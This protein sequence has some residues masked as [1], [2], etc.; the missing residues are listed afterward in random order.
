MRIISGIYKSRKIIPPKGGDIVRPTSDRAKETL[1]NTVSNFFEFEGA[2]VVDLYCGSGAIGLEF[3]SRGAKRCVFVDENV[4]TVSRNVEALGCGD[5]SLIMKD[6][7]L[8]YIKYEIEADLIFA[9]PPYSY[10]VYEELL[11]LVS[12]QKCYFILEHSGDVKIPEKLKKKI[13]K[14]KK[15]GIAMFTFFDLNN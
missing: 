6:C 12:K 8:S 11:N 1:F 15:E 4:E 7:C 2:R 10:R 9:D 5:R 3:I 14:E 13:F